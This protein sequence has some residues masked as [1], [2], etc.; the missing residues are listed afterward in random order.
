NYV[1]EELQSEG[2]AIRVA[3]NAVPAVLFLLFRKR[4]APEAQERRLWTWMAVFALTCLPLVGLA[5]TA[6][7]R[8][9]LYLIPIQLFAFSRVPRLA[10]S[11]AIRTLLVLG[12]VSYYAVAQFVWLNYATHAEYWAPYHFMPFGQ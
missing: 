10:T 7:D 11:V 9:A 8:V 1:E 2:G 12:I 6:V 3:M 5:S 4:L